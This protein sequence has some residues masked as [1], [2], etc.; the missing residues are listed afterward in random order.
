MLL[1]V[2]R[3]MVFH[4]RCRESNRDLCCYVEISSALR[5]S[6][7]CIPWFLSAANG[8]S[9]PRPRFS[10]DISSTTPRYITDLASTFP[11]SLPRP[12][13][14]KKAGD[15]ISALRTDHTE[16]HLSTRGR[17]CATKAAPRMLVLT[18]LTT[19]CGARVHSRK[20][21]PSR[22]AQVRR[23]WVFLQATR[24]GEKVGI[25]TVSTVLPIRSTLRSAAP[26]S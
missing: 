1:L 17:G 7:A 9:N 4:I 16:V 20:H 2:H 23:R 13:L 14:S 21:T 10:H 25:R 15:Y 5:T 11:K 8:F 3:G 12:W 19:T 6:S 26:H 22:I 24:R 18:R